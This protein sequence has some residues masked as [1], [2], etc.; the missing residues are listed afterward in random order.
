MFDE[1]NAG[2]KIALLIDGDNAQASIFGKVLSEIGRYGSITIRRIYGDWT[3]REMSSWKKALEIHAIQ[4]IQQFRYTIGKNA[5]DSALI[6]DAMDILHDGYVNGFGIVSSDSDFTKLA[7]RIREKGLFVIGVGEK[8]TP[9]AFVKA[10]DIFVFTEILRIPDED[11]EMK[12]EVSSNE[13]SGESA[14]KDP[15][16]I[17]REAIE[18]VIREDGWAHLSPIGMA[19]RKMDPSFDSRTYGHKQL[20]Q[21]IK[22]YP[23]VFEL[24]YDKE[25]IGDVHVH[26]LESDNI[27]VEEIIEKL[28]LD[29]KYITV[30]K[31]NGYDNCSHLKDLS[32]NDMLKLGN[33]NPTTARKILSYCV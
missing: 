28:N 27:P 5:T 6:I 31:E 11:R 32:V 17:I 24:K 7:T 14:E 1:N 33:M 21:L 16:P 30:L 18:M 29:K 3:T 15:V 23:E 13:S 12:K 4:P 25:K 26:I 22:S 10:C 9:E 2:N 20:S 19:L 8:K